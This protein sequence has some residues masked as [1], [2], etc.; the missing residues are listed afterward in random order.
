MSHMTIKNLPC[1]MQ[2]ANVFGLISLE[3]K[4][5]LMK[6]SYIQIKQ[7]SGFSKSHSNTVL[8]PNNCNTQHILHT[9]DYYININNVKCNQDKKKEH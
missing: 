4:E 8:I 1:P 3:R 6:Q 5:S 9:L 7:L 2:S